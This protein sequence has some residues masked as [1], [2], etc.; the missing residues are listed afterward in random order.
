[1]GLSNSEDDEFDLTESSSL[2]RSAKRQPVQKRPQHKPRLQDPQSYGSPRHNPKPSK[3]AATTGLSDSD[4]D[5]FNIT[6]TDVDL[7]ASLSRTSRPR[8][9]T[10][11]RLTSFAIDISEED[12]ED[13]ADDDFDYQDPRPP[14]QRPSGR[15]FVI[16][17]DDDSDVPVAV[18]DDDD[19]VNWSELEKE[20]EDEGYNGERSVNV[21]EPEG[22]VVGMALRK[23]SRISSDL[24]KELFGSSARDCES[25]AEIDASTCRIVTQVNCMVLWYM[26]F[27][28]F[29][30]SFETKI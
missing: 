29:F 5:D 23:C 21:E 27:K 4:D 12:E 8:R 6:D 7:P 10:S 3:A 16:G 9:T 13:L 14:Q 22:D 11:R 20:D 17:D 2:H 28:F 19:G 30:L 1:V 15:R 25:Y 24:R 26:L 18:D